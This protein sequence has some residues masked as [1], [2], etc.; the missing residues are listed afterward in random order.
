[1][2]T[3]DDTAPET[4]A[5]AG[6]KPTWV[7]PP[8]PN[9][10][11]GGY[12]TPGQTWPPQ[13]VGSPPGHVV[14]DALEP[15]EA[16]DPGDDQAPAPKRKYG[17]TLAGGSLVLV[18][19]AMAAMSAAG[20]PAAL[21]AA[22]AGGGVATGAAV[23]GGVTAAGAAGIAYARRR[24]RGDRPGRTRREPSER[25]RNEKAD[26]RD[27]GRA[28]DRGG[29]APRIPN[30]FGGGPGGGRRAGAA[31]P[32]LG[33]AAR[34]AGAG[35]AGAG[36]AGAAPKG[37]LGRAL[38]SAMPGGGGAARKATAGAGAAGAARKATANRTP[39]LPKRPGRAGGGG[40]FS[41]P[42]LFG[43]SGGRRSP[44]SASKHASN[45]GRAAASSPRTG[46]G[47]RPT[48]RQQYAS[49]RDARRQQR[50]DRGD[51]RRQA[52]AGRRDVLREARATRRSARRDA[53]RQRWTERK[54]VLGQLTGAPER[55]QR[56]QQR[57]QAVVDRRQVR[58]KQRWDRRDQRREER[59]DRRGQR[60][61]QRR[62]KLRAFMGRR[63]RKLRTRRRV[64]RMGMSVARRRIAGY[65]PNWYSRIKA[66][67][68][69]SGVGRIAANAFWGRA[70]GVWASIVAT[71]RQIPAWLWAPDPTLGSQPKHQAVAQPPQHRP[72]A[73]KTPVQQILNPA[74]AGP[75]PPR[76][77][78]PV[79]RP[80]PAATA[81]VP[82]PTPAPPVP[83]PIA[84]KKAVVTV[85]SSGR[86][87]H[88]D[89]DSIVTA[90]EDNLG[91]YEM[92]NT[93]GHHAF[94]A[95][96]AD[97]PSALGE[98]FATVAGHFEGETPLDQSVADFMR[99]MAQACESAATTAGELFD[100]WSTQHEYDINRALDPRPGEELLDYSRTI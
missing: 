51:A 48:A 64:A 40:G 99:E 87:L 29:R 59:R 18:I 12:F 79:T 55:A 31:T 13:E 38:R 46:A 34:R 24:R 35:R 72:A 57:R 84:R 89:I 69:G 74:P 43:G 32:G 36:R 42:K 56:R 5:T 41:L 71:V 73:G 63:L 9:P 77:V 14:D 78:P 81:P 44:G 97:I 88:P 15:A 80:A 67:H 10:R 83:P 30:L 65:R 17:K 47:G 19:L 93:E 6:D 22:V 96:L 7:M 1:M 16:D 98:A 54:D 94:L 26:R 82:R 21:A 90:F 37:A 8:L 33:G 85:S 11:G 49:R 23:G 92:T 45:G 27:S 76:I 58:R 2:T 50:W 91:G 25:R 70:M 4:P 62:S 100:A 39:G 20:G 3:T 60:R 28:R 53:R 86:G 52:R 75:T 95:S 66:L 61:D 68:P